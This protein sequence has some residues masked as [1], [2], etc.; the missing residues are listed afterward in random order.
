MRQGDALS[1][2]L[3]II[4]MEALH[5]LIEKA[6]ELQFL[7]G[8]TISIRNKTIEIS[9]LFFA[10]DTLIFCQPEIHSLIFLRNILSSFQAVS[11]LKINLHKSAMVILGAGDDNVDSL[12]DILRCRLSLLPVTYLGVPLG[13]KHKDSKIWDPVIDMIQNRLATWKK[14]FL[15]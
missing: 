12:K 15:S 1:P 7:K 6:K 5:K 11:G 13:A 14:K 4:V 10:N 8:V 3:F 9:H 2:L